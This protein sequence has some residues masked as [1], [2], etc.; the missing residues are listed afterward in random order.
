[1]GR[2]KIEEL[3]G[4]QKQGIEYDQYRMMQ[5]ALK[6]AQKKVIPDM[7]NAGIMKNKIF[8]WQSPLRFDSIIDWIIQGQ[9]C[10]GIG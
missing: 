2:S 5:N 3:N 1:M 10:G 7:I 4:Q 6:G 8:T 9:L